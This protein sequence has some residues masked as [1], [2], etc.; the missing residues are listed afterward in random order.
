[1]KRRFVRNQLRSQPRDRLAGG[2]SSSP[3]LILPIAPC[4]DMAHGPFGGGKGSFER[5]LIPSFLQNDPKVFQPVF[6]R[7]I[8]LVEIKSQR[9]CN[10]PPCFLDEMAVF[11]SS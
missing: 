3:H 1:M 5:I 8:V 6:S 11:W 9:G 10:K 4:K 7:A 2:A